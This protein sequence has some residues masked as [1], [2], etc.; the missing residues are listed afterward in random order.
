MKTA[1]IGFYRTDGDF[2]IVATFNNNDDWISEELFE[3][4][5][6]AA[7]VTISLA[8]PEESIITLCEQHAPDYVDVAQ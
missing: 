4:L 1:T 5:V 7:R 6:E 8:I 2:Q 3:S